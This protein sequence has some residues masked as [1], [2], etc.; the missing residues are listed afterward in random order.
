MPSV[1]IR[2][3]DG[4]GRT[5]RLPLTTATTAISAAT[6]TA[7]ISAVTGRP[8]DRPTEPIDKAKETETIE[9]YIEK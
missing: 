3:V 7:T 5:E 1:A 8:V 2:P 6:T 4:G 9:E